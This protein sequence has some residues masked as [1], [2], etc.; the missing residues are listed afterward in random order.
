LRVDKAP[1]VQSAIL[2][3]NIWEACRFTL[4][5]IA[6]VQENSDVSHQAPYGRRTTRPLHQQRPLPSLAAGS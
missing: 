2:I 1:I 3:D 6:D 4:I 5:D